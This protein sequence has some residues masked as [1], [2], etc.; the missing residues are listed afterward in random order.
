[1]DR[2]EEQDGKQVSKN[3]ASLALSS[4]AVVR[5]CGVPRI[6]DS[7]KPARKYNYTPTPIDKMQTVASVGNLAISGADY[8][9]WKLNNALCVQQELMVYACVHSLRVKLWQRI[10]DGDASSLRIVHGPFTWV[11]IAPAQFALDLYCVV[12]NRFY[13][14]RVFISL[15]LIEI[16]CFTIQDADDLRELLLAMTS[17]MEPKVGLRIDVRPWAFNN[18]GNQIQLEQVDWQS[19]RCLLPHEQLLNLP[20]PSPVPVVDTAD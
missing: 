12:M 16:A 10:E 19:G 15:V 13:S 3:I 6:H 2:N 14:E 20:A 5:F 11:D 17:V 1:L 7:S 18:V 9:G 4:T 8:M